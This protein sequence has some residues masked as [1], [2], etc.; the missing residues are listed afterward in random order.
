MNTGD[1]NNQKIN[2]KKIR[3]LFLDPTAFDQWAINYRLSLKQEQRNDAS[4][5]KAM[6]QVNPRYILRNH[7]AQIAIEKAEQGDFSETD[8]LLALLQK[9]FMQQQGM[10][11]YAERPPAWASEI[12]ISCSS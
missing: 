11:S 10:E 3:E 6:Q 12:S 9:P 7:L 4:R 5:H 8:R 1:K 2:D